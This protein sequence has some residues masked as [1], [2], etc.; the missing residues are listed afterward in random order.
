MLTRTHARSRARARAPH[1]VT[2]CRDMQ[3]STH[4]HSHNLEHPPAPTDRVSPRAAPAPAA[5]HR[6]ADSEPG[7]DR[8]LP[9]HPAPLYP[10]D[11][12]L[13]PSPRRGEPTPAA[14]FLESVRR[15]P[16]GPGPPSLALG[17]SSLPIPRCRLRS[18]PIRQLEGGNRQ[19]AVHPSRH[20]PALRA[21]TRRPTDGLVRR[22]P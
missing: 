20:R 4:S 22:T 3:T 12:Q 21:V 2:P 18:G 7:G 5:A 11:L 15:P 13:E 8:P 19:D 16:A 14:H 10:S 6:L 9:R 1:T 17:R